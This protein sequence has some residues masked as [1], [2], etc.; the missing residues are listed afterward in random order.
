MEIYE[1]QKAFRLRALSLQEEIQG[2]KL[3]E[4]FQQLTSH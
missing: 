2:K 4:L 3:L 1:T